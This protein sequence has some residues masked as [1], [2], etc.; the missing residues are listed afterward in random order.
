MSKRGKKAGF[1]GSGNMATALIK[2]IINSG[3]YSPDMI[4]AHDSDP[5]KLKSIYETYGIEGMPSNSDLVKSC[6]I[7]ILAVKPQV[8]HAVLEEIR[9]G[10]DK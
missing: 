6:N 9:N 3:L 7:I 10:D 2:G 1:I 4:Y 5:E 8:M